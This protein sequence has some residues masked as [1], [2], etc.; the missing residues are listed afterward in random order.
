MKKITTLLFT[1]IM[2]I[3]YSQNFTYDKI[4]SMGQ[5]IKL[6]GKI[7]VTDSLI[8]I[9]SNGVPT[10]FKVKKVTDTQAHKMYE[11]LE[12][13]NGT[14]MRVSLNRP[15]EPDKYNPNALVLET[16]RAFSET[17]DMILYYIKED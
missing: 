17:Y 4:S 8:T 10:S 13:G 9:Y 3:S 15:I 16:K 1:L 2:A 11:A 14:E 7:T 5:T 6:K 12:M